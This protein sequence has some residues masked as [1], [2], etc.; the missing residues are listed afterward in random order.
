MVMVCSGDRSTTSSSFSFLSCSLIVTW[1]NNLV[2]KKRS[3]FLKKIP[4]VSRASVGISF[5]SCCRQFTDLLASVGGKREEWGA[6][7][8]GRRVNGFVRFL[9]NQPTWSCDMLRV[10]S[11][12]LAKK[13]VDP[14]RDDSDIAPP[15]T[16]TTPTY[17]SPQSALPQGSSGISK[18]KSPNGMQQL[19]ITPADPQ[20]SIFYFLYLFPSFH[21]SFCLRYAFPLGFNA[22]VYGFISYTKSLYL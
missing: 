10:G 22:A 17:T 6:R 16:T 9:K 13:N 21:H 7:R 14:R 1:S 4:D 19:T 11:N 8:G 2:E 5:L 3:F 20:L 15:P 18:K 12:D